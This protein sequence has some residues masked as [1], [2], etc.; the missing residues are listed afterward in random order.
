MSDGA[1][2]RDHAEVDESADRATTFEENFKSK[3]AWLRLLFM[4][5]VALLY[6]ISRMVLGAVVLIQFCYVLATGSTHGPLLQ[7]GRSLA[8]YAYQV[9][10]FL[11]FNS[12][13]RPFP[14][15]ADWPVAADA[16]ATDGDD[17]EPA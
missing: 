14:F 5:V 4:V 8:I 17:A 11:T 6:G 15:D 12:E 16:G 13:T 10:L 3:S 2:P 9:V 7:F 1:P